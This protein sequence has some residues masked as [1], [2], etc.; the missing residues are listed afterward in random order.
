MEKLVPDIIHYY[1]LEFLT[2]KFIT[3]DSI[4]RSKKIKKKHIYFDEIR[5]AEVFAVATAT[6]RDAKIP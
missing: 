3:T 4:W 6:T 5:Y 2:Q 1:E